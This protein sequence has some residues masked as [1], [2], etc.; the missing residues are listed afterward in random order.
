MAALPYPM[1]YL[2]EKSSGK[3]SASIK[4]ADIQ[5]MI[6]IKERVEN[7]AG[8]LHPRLLLAEGIE[9]NGY[10]FLS[11]QGPVIAVNIGM[12]NL[13][14]QDQ[15]AMAAL[16]GHELAHLHLN[17]G[18]LR[19][20]R[21]DNRIAA[22]VALSFALGMF[23][24]PVPMEVTDIATTS[25]TSKFSREEERDADRVGVEYMV[26]AGFD[27][28]GSVRLQ[29]KLGAASS[30]DLVTFLS[31]HP[32]GTERIENMKRL[33]LE[34]QPGRAALPSENKGGPENRNISP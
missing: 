7:A 18:R 24:I 2:K 29:E 34:Y 14:G 30:G 15:D 22:S 26:K 32:S 20:D 31:S 23:G 3:T 25:V 10:S 5:Q 19:R 9:P 33:A 16:I 28:F 21:E 27:P 4:M 12:L 1:V 8:P 17:H 11:K 13:I 6:S